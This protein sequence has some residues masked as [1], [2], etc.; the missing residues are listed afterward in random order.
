M[1]FTA[2]FIAQRIKY[3]TWSRISVTD[4]DRAFILLC[5]TVSMV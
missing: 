1:E 2:H 5:V 4:L 3:G